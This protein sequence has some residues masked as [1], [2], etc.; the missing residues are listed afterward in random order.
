MF[1]QTVNQ[2]RIAF[3]F[4][5]VVLVGT[6]ILYIIWGSGEQQWWDDVDKLGYPPGWKHGPLM[7]R[8]QDKE[9]KI[10]HPKHDHSPVSND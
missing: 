6:N 9:K 7:K 1:Q 4:V 2:W 8:E 3:W 10:V 5:F